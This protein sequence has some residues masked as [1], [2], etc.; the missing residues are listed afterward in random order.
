MKCRSTLLLSLLLLSGVSFAA[1]GRKT[2]GE[3]K[4]PGGL[5]KV[6]T[7]CLDQ[8]DLPRETVSDLKKFAEDAGK[9][10]GLFSKLQWQPV[11]NCSSADVTV[12]LTLEAHE[13]LALAGDGTA[14]QDMSEAV[15]SEMISRVKMLVTDRESGRTLYQVDGG[16]VTNDR[17]GAFASPFS[18]LLKDLK[19]LK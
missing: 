16:P 17:Q 11:D 18:K 1:D 7:F 6:H 5:L 3:V 10:R 13:K 2:R 12:K 15:R 8:S 14:M 9:P 19:T 4:D